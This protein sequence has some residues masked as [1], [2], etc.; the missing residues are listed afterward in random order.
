MANLEMV[1][2]GEICNQK[3][4]VNPGPLLSWEY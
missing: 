2:E 1:V 3:Q 4:E